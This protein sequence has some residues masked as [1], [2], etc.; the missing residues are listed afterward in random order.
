MKLCFVS[1]GCD[2]NL[3]DSERMI[4]LL[5]K[6]G[7]ELTDLEE[8]A[9]VIVVNTCCFI[10]SAKSESI[11]EILRLAQYKEDGACRCLIVAGCLAQR[12]PAEIQKELPEAD[13]LVGT[14]AIGDIVDAVRASLKEKGT[15]FL[16]PPEEAADINTGRIIATPGNYEYLKIAEGCGRRCT[17]CIIPAIRGRYRSVPEPV[18]LK[19]AEELAQR[20]VK[21]LILV[22]QETGLYGS[23]LY[24]KKT[25][26]ELLS[27]LS[28]IEGIRWIRI[29]YYYPEEV[30]AEFIEAVRSLPKVLPY[31]DMPVQHASDRILKAMGRRTSQAELRAVVERLRREIPEITLRTTLISGFPGE[32][33]EDHEELK[34]FVSEMRFDR[35]G[36]FPYSEEEGTPAA[37]FPDQVPEKE[38]KRRR[39]EIMELQQKI[40]FEEGK[41]LIGRSFEVQIEGRLPEENAFIGR[42]RRD[43]PEVDGFFFLEEKRGMREY[44]TG[45]F[46]RAWVTGTR[47]YDLTGVL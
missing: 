39:D 40:V 6:E 35:L 27:R 36:V 34:R 31:L 9:E 15:V 45:D 16:R 14:G 25:L 23:D 24:G 7:F 20:G 29:M 10:D 3:V 8:E 32:T 44:M 41:K 38:R 13:A 5:S 47:G 2:K 22:A 17:Y 21:E 1:L 4:T 30:T 43:A 18:L 28:D 11:E 33:E 46:V 42:T 19:E 37:S 12:Y 26:P